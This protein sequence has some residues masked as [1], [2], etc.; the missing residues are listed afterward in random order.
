MLAE[1]RRADG[2]LAFLAALICEPKLTSGRNY[3]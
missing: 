2:V 1:R 3:A